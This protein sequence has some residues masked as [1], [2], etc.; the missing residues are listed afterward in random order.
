MMLIMISRMIMMS[1]MMIMIITMIMMM[2]ITIII[3]QFPSGYYDENVSYYM[4][5]LL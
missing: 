1:R 3:K 2:T 5:Q 4:S